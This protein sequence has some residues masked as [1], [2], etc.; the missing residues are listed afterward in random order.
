MK[1]DASKSWYANEP[2]SGVVGLER[3]D[4]EPAEASVNLQGGVA[5]GNFPGDFDLVRKADDSQGGTKNGVNPFR[6]IDEWV[7]VVLVD[8]ED[9]VVALA[10][11]VAK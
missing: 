11:R 10:V 1:G 5:E 6:V 2:V 8:G 3:F 9:E 4:G 7:A